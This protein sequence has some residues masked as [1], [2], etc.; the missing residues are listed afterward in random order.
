VEHKVYKLRTKGNGKSGKVYTYE[1]K[2]CFPKESIGDL[3]ILIGAENVCLLLKYFSGC[4]MY[5]P[6][7][8]S[9]KRKIIEACIA[10]ESGRML[11]EGKTRQETV[12]VLL[13]TFAGRLSRK[14][15]ENKLVDWFG[16]EGREDPLKR[17]RRECLLDEVARHRDVF[18][19]YGMI[20]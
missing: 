9:I 3:I 16:K 2:W 8:R 12:D 18:R 11:R 10:N 1:Q 15:L 13:E 7:A 4:K 5:V 6:T 20:D 19:R 17:A 14:G